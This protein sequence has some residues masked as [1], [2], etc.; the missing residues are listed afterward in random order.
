MPAGRED[1]PLLHKLNPVLH[2]KRE[3]LLHQRLRLAVAEDPDIRISS[4]QLLKRRGVIRLHVMDN[5]I[6]KMPSV[7]HLLHVL[8]KHCSDSGIN[9]VTQDCL[10]IQEQIRIIRNTIRNRVH[11]LEHCQTP[12][13][14]SYPVQVVHYFSVTVHVLFLSSFQPDDVPCRHSIPS[15]PQMPPL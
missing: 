2:V 11:S 8:K 13:I 15:F 14:R 12:V 5:H 9:R 7:Q 6:I 1:I 10:L 4:D 3:K